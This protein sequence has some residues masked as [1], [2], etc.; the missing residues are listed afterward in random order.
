MSFKLQSPYPPLGDQPQA[1][2]KLLKRIRSGE[3][4]S[5]LLGVT[6]SGKTFTMANVAA[7]LDPPKPVLSHTKTL[8]APPGALAQQR[9]GRAA[10]QRVQAI[11]P[12]QRG[13]IFCLLLRFLP[14]RGLHS[15]QRLL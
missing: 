15:A 7:A 13:R 12:R 5:T 10:L 11:L 8:A 4:H 9:A 1:I 6:G 14:A 2:E 3:K